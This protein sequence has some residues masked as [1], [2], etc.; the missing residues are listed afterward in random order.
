MYANS[1]SAD[2]P[3]QP[4]S[5]I[6]TFV[7]RS[8]KVIISQLVSC[9]QCHSSNLHC[10]WTGWLEHAMT[11]LETQWSGF[12]VLGSIFKTAPPCYLPFSEQSSP[13]Q[14]S[15]HWHSCLTK[16]FSQVPPFSQGL[17]L[18]GSIMKTFILQAKYV[19]HLSGME[20]PTLIFPI[21]L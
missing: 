4:C 13:V 17:F 2:Q 15:V 3:V 1:K 20:F 8:M 5:L 16:T 12:I 14:G 9:I 19:S 18:H 6:S 7:T 21:T 11:C 10:S